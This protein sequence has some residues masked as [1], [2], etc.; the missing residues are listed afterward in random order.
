[1]V[2]SSA[3]GNKTVDGTVEGTVDGT[4]VVGL[5]AVALEQVVVLPR[6]VQVVES[7]P[8]WVEVQPLEV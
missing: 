5:V 6:E 1:M 8:F 2:A 4:A 7:V 3:V